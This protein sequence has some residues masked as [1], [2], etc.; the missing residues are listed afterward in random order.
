MQKYY[1][2]YD[3]S[4]WRVG[5]VESKNEF[6][7]SAPAADGEAPK[8]A[9]KTLLDKIQK[10]ASDAKKEDDSQNNTQTTA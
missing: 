5:L 1:T 9:D 7:A 4:K 8:S 6:A 2:I 10:D 3:H